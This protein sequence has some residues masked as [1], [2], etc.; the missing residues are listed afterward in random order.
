MGIQ[1]GDGQ[2]QAGDTALAVGLHGGLPGGVIDVPEI[3]AVQVLEVVLLGLG[4]HDHAG[5]PL[6]HLDKGLKQDGATLLDELADGVEVLRVG[7]H[8]RVEALAVLALALGEGLDPP[9]GE[10]VQPGLKEGHHLQPEAVLIHQ[11]PQAGVAEGDVLLRRLGKEPVPH[12]PHALGDGLD[13]DA[14]HRHGEQ[15][16]VAADGVPAADGAGKLQEGVAVVPAQLM[17]GGVGGAGGEDPPGGLRLP[18]PLLQV[19]PQHA[20]GDAGL[21]GFKILGDAVD[22]DGLV[23]VQLLQGAGHLAGGDGVARP[24]DGGA[25]LGPQGLHRRPGGLVGAADA[26]DH[27]GVGVGAHPGRL[28]QQKVHPLRSGVV[29]H[30]EPA[31]IVLML[32]LT[33]HHT[34]QQGGG[35]T[36]LLLQLPG[37]QHRLAVLEGEGNILHVTRPP[38]RSAQ[39][40]PPGRPSPPEAPCRSC[41]TPRSGC[42]RP[43]SRHGAWRR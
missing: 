7:G 13:V 38:W 36:E 27:K 21:Q 11:V 34:G 3:L 5:I 39:P 37:S 16:H 20:E 9:L 40:Y 26:D 31:Q 29:V 18:V 42:P 8:H 23:A 1:S 30:P 41:Q 35:G 6:P 17:E 12:V 15:A 2:V 19:V 22:I 33:G 25:V 14:R 28:L 24:Q 10:V 43:P 4:G 32:L